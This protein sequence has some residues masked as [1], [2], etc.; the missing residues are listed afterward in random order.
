MCSNALN[1]FECIK[2]NPRAYLWSNGSCERSRQLKY[3]FRLFLFFL[4]FFCLESDNLGYLAPFF[5]DQ[6]AIGVSAASG[7]NVMSSGDNEDWMARTL[8]AMLGDFCT[9]ICIQAYIWLFQCRTANY[10]CRN[11]LVVMRARN[12]GNYRGAHYTFI[13][14]ARCKWMLRLQMDGI[15]RYENEAFLSLNVPLQ[16]G[17]LPLFVT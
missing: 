13:R 4:L 2:S 1:V 12:D 17:Y 11:H 16:N 3:D 6:L 7:R 15:T 5:G 9:F 8:L 10:M 14:L